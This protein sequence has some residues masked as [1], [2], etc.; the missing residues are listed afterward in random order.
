MV[1]ASHSAKQP[2][3]SVSFWRDMATVVQLLTRYCNTESG[4]G[5]GVTVWQRRSARGKWKLISPSN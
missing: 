3:P 5:T 2:G 4:C 1:A